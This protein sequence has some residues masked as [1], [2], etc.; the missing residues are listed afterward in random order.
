MDSGWDYKDSMLAFMDTVNKRRVILSSEGWIC[1]VPETAMV[2]NKIVVLTSGQVF[3]IVR[4]KSQGHGINDTL[5]SLIRET[6]FGGFMDE[7]HWMNN[8]YSLLSSVSFCELPL[9]QAGFL[10]KG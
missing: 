10:R 4:E 8:R 1:L 2:G 6:Y 7:T 5:H 9:I 3:N